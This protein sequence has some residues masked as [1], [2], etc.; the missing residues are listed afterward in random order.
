MDI[1]TKY[2]IIPTKPWK[3]TTKCLTFTTKTSFI[4]TKPIPIKNKQT[5]RFVVLKN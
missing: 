3:I 2:A 1:L 5:Y 4:T